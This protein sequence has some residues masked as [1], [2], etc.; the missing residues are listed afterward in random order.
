M[1]EE[2]PWVTDEGDTPYLSIRLECFV[3]DISLNDFSDLHNLTGDLARDSPRCCVKFQARER[4]CGFFHP[5][6]GERYGK[7]V[8]STLQSLFNC[9]INTLVS[10][11]LC[12]S[13]APRELA[14]RREMH[15]F[16]YRALTK[17]RFLR[18]VA[19][20]SGQPR[21]LKKAMGNTVADI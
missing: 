19:T 2:K 7:L 6:S 3:I 21:F 11:L 8:H 16:C 20:Q 12:A 14:L 9:F 15:G 17:L 4:R 10:T 1:D 18:A 5:E 13:V